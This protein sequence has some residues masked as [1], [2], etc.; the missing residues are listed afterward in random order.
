MLKKFHWKLTMIYFSLFLISFGIAGEVLSPVLMR[1]FEAN[2]ARHLGM[3]SQLVLT[4]VR[5]YLGDNQAGELDKLVKEMGKDLAIRITVI[6]PQGQVLAESQKD[7]K[8]MGNHSDRPEVQEALQGKTGS[9]VRYSNTLG[10]PMLYMAVPVKLAGGAPG[11]LRLAIPMTNIRQSVAQVRQILIVGTGIALA[12][13]TILA[14]YIA[15]R[16]TSPIRELTQVA[17]ELA[18]GNFRARVKVRTGDELGYLSSTLNH[19][20]TGLQNMIEDISN[21]KNKIRA[22]LTSMGD[23]VVALDSDG[24]I[25]LVNQAAERMFGRRETEVVGKYI[26]SLVRNYKIEELVSQVVAS[27]KVIIDELK[28]ATGPDRILRIHGAPIISDAAKIVGVALVFRDITGLR[29][30]EQMRTDFVANVSHELKTPLTS[31]KGFVETLLDGAMEDSEVSRRFLGIINEETDRLHRLIADLLSLAH[32]EA[33][34]FEAAY[35]EA[36][37]EQV[38]GKTAA[39]LTPLAEAKGISLSLELDPGL[40]KVIIKEDLLGQIVLNLMD[41]AIKYTLSGGR[42]L[43]KARREQEQVVVEVSDTG[44]GIP[45]ESL[46]RIFERFYRVDKARSREIGGTGLGLSIVKHILERYGQK[47]WVESTPGKGSV[48]SF[49]LAAAQESK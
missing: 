34:R 6:G 42:V 46:P 24:R 18:Q 21:E 11:V 30:L 3:E 48:F 31:I 36:E 32:I 15:R 27:R 39:I 29:Q 8:Q 12:L 43:V 9:A 23:G 25:I 14:F 13:S 16:F 5:P 47:I 22:I 45:E 33:P 49:T 28:S 41:N 44:I 38:V 40:P 10:Y 20:A 17:Q 35:Q 19:M 26:L 1:Y 7:T 2:E 4:A 37:L